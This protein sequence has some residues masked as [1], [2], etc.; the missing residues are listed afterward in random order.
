M[1]RTNI[2]KSM[3]GWSIS[4]F[5]Y[6]YIFMSNNNHIFIYLYKFGVG[7][8]FSLIRHWSLLCTSTEKF[9]FSLCLKCR[10]FHANDRASNQFYR[11]ITV[12]GQRAEYGINV[13]DM[14]LLW[15]VSIL[16]RAWNRGHSQIS[17]WSHS[18]LGNMK[19]RSQQK[20]QYSTKNSL[21]SQNVGNWTSG[22]KLSL[23]IMEKGSGFWKFKLQNLQ[24]PST[25]PHTELPCYNFKIVY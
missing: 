18:Y 15:M 7:G 6:I 12:F 2:N 1:Y 17:Q 5:Y 19:H 9:Y 10:L 14:M 3:H 20:S 25:S 16:R 4:M 13:N 11:I 21:I 22:D 8:F 23:I 24:N